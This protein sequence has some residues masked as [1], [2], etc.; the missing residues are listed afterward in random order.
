VANLARVRDRIEAAG[1]DLDRITIVAVTKGF[2]VDHVR[3]A[4]AAGLV[5]IGENYAHE[6]SAK[7]PPTR[8]LRLGVRW[9]FLGHIQ[10][11][12]VRQIAGGVH[13]WQGVDRLSAGEEIARRA[14]GA[15]VLVQVNLT[16]DPDRNGCS[17]D[18]AAPLVTALTGLGLDVRGLMGVGPAGDPEDGRAAFRRLAALTAELALPEVSMGM[19]DDLE[20][21]VEEGSTMVRVGT[22]LFGPRHQARKVER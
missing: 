20:V 22:A 19:T 15:A 5:D 10:R 14:P 6:L 1:G 9:H 13:V 11:N 17:W 18:D 8:L 4:A 21:A 2:S 12:K 16:A 7:M 3:L